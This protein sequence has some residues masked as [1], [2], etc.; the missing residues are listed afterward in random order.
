MPALPPKS[1]TRSFD[2]LSEA[3]A[4]AQSARVYAGIHFREG[5]QAGAR[6]GTQIGRFVALHAFRPHGAV[7][8]R[9]K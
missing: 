5:C 6:Q 4:E 9:S 3:S 8:G 1:I 7:A 2:T